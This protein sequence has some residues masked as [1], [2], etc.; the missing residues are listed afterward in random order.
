[1]QKFPTSIFSRKELLGPIIVINAPPVFQA[2]WGIAKYFVTSRTRKKV[3][4][5]GRDFEAKLSELI[6]AKDAKYK[7]CV[8]GY[9]CD[10]YNVR[11]LVKETMTQADRSFGSDS[12]KDLKTADV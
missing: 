3:S 4:V 2:I 9:L 1:M 11:R 5:Y 10:S 12:S 8:V 7:I 6:S